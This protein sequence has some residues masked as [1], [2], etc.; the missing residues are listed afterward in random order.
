MD[1]IDFMITNGIINVSKTPITLRSGK[2]SHWYINWR[3]AFE[4]VSLINQL[5][6]MIL[7]KMIADGILPDCFYGVPES[8]SKLATILQYKYTIGARFDSPT[9]YRNQLPMGR[10]KPKDH[11]MMEDRFFLGTPSGRT[12]IIE[13]V[14]T[15]GGKLL[16]EV[17]K[18]EAHTEAEI[19]AIV[20]L[21][22]RTDHE[23]FN[24]ITKNVN[25]PII[26]MA[27]GHKV[28][29]QAIQELN[30]PQN[31]LQSLKEECGDAINIPL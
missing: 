12:V 27:N 4:R 1:I 8:A 11:G 10:G 20:V 29:Q 7:S 13:D 22:D 21:T 31:V 6:D 2:K 26:V 3:I 17:E 18:I 14:I 28:L 9:H 16:Q 25:A 30:I 23:S 24:N 15:T 5:S 19:V